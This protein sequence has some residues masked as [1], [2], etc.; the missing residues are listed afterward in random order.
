M[1]YKKLKSNIEKIELLCITEEIT[2]KLLRCLNL[3]KT[4]RMDEISPKFLKDIIEVLT[5]PICD[6][7]NLSTKL[8]TFPDK[9]KLAK[10]LPLFEKD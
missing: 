10:L 2:D 9:C 3:S 5:R 7:K 6:I 1:F 4:P 8:S